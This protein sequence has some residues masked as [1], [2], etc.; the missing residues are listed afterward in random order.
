MTLAEQ[1]DALAAL[2]NPGPTTGM[3]PV[4]LLD[5]IVPDLW[6]GGCIG[7]TRLPDDFRYVL[8]LTPQDEYVLGPDAER[9]SY[10][11]D[12]GPDVPPDA[13]LEDLA[14]WVNSR[15]GKTLVH[16]SGGRNRSGLVMALALVRRG[17]P[18]DDAI[19]L[20]REK[21]SAEVLWNTHFVDWLREH[22]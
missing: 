12:D 15:D 16:C 4:N 22:A 18:L 14:A 13:D 8:S 7:G 5:E 11:F 17:V 10:H 21:R 2:Q 19:A 3:P 1:Y 20:M 9:R 6:L